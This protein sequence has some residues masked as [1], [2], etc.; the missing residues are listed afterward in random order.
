MQGDLLNVIFDVRQLGLERSD[1]DNGRFSFPLV[2]LLDYVAPHSHALDVRSCLHGSDFAP[3]HN[4]VCD[5]MTRS[6]VSSVPPCTGWSSS[7]CVTGFLLEGNAI[8]KH[9]VGDCP[10]SSSSSTSASFTVAHIVSLFG[11]LLSRMLHRLLDDLIFAVQ[12]SPEA[13][14][15]VIELLL[16]S[17]RF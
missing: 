12:V 5:V 11:Q 8:N 3:S 7:L 15:L 10:M 9:S 6:L 14:Q 1:R 17:I 4:S 13:L 16:I 2:R